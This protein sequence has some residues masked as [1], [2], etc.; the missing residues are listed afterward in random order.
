MSA[1]N[2]GETEGAVRLCQVNDV[3]EGNGLQINLP[4][5]PPLAVFKIEGHIFV[6]DDTCTHGQASLCEGEIEDGVV[7]CPF[8]QG[9]FEIA[10]GK[11]ISAPCSVHLKTYQPIL[12]GDDVFVHLDKSSS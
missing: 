5:R 6:T 11:A 2:L 8:H 9:A 12:V 3:A 1:S 7:E 10:T 4:E